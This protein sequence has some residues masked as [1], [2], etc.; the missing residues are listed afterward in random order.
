MSL[1]EK[2][3]CIIEKHLG[4]IP[5]PDIYNFQEFFR[6][7]VDLTVIEALEHKVFHKKD[8][9]RTDDYIIRIKPEGVKK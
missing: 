5:T 3:N 1:Q 2:N 8:F 7:L 6:W 9:I 4:R